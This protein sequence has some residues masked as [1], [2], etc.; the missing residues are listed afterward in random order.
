VPMSGKLEV[1][2]ELKN[3]SGRAGYETDL[4]DPQDRHSFPNGSE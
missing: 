4:P 2:K 3:R 1:H